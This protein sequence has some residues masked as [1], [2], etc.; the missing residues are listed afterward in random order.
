M[1]YLLFYDYCADVLE[2]RGPHR[3][4]HLARAWDAESR[5]EL[6]LAG[7][8]GSP[9]DGAVFHFRAD[10][11]AVVEAF[12]AADP[13]VRHG[14]VTRWTIREWLTVVGEAAATPTGKP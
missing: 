9:V 3:D 6:V 2:K 11:P 12:V 1:D 14:L 7:A 13:Y 5:G 8:L 4:E 10:S